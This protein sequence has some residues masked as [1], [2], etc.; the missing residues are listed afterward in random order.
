M[1]WVRGGG[2]RKTSE[3][4]TVCP[5]DRRLPP[6]RA[7]AGRK[8]GRRDTKKPRALEISIF[9]RENATNAASHSNEINVRTSSADASSRACVVRLDFFNFSI[10]E[11]V[12]KK[13]R[14]CECATLSSGE[15]GEEASN[16]KRAQKRQSYF[17]ESVDG[18]SS[19]RDS[20]IS[21]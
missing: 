9:S 17:H 19:F 5:Y 14:E 21:S 1:V 4:R 20:D 10:E 6:E 3:H 8:E 16:A 12:R 7:R 11:R 2:K 15:G 13:S 18:N